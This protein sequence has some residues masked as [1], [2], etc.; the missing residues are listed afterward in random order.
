MSWRSLDDM[1]HITQG[2]DVVNPE[3]KHPQLVIVSE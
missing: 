2:V 1:K 3:Y